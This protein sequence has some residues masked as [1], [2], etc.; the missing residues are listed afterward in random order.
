MKISG[1]LG[2]TFALV[3]GLAVAAIV[4]AQTAPTATPA[5]PALIG[6]LR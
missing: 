2:R 1:N 4:S 3:A 6:E 5:K